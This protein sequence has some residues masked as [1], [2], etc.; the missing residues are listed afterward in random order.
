MATREELEAQIEADPTDDAAYLILGDLLQLE[1]DPRGE[2][3]ALD[4][5]Y[6]RGSDRASW[7]RRR[8]ELLDHHLELLPRTGASI[9][10]T[11]HL[12]FVRRVALGSSRNYH[13]IFGHPSLRFVTELVFLDPHGRDDFVALFVEACRSCPL[14]RSLGI[15]DPD[16]RHYYWP[17]DRAV[18]DLGALATLPRLEQLY[19]CEPIEL[20]TVPDLRWLRLEGD[21]DVL[22]RLQRTP[23]PALQQLSLR[24]ARLGPDGTLAHVRWLLDHPPPNLVELELIGASGDL[25]IPALAGSPLL[26]QLRS[27]RLWNAGLTETAARAITP[28][29]FGHLALLDLS[30]PLLDDATIAT[31]AGACPDV[32]T[33]SPWMRVILDRPG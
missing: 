31:V 21:P 15:G 14:V 8:A 18:L 32:R 1:G 9:H 33:I 25:L 24:D 23:L 27:L 16:R 22:V 4:A 2:L 13:A 19:A 7:A 17:R 20:G 29:R 6:L 28:A 10:Y 3:I 5:A 11:W 26:A 12:G 30:D